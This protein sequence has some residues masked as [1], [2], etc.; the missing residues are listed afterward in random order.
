MARRPSRRP[1]LAAAFLALAAFP[2]GSALAAPAAP[3]ARPL[4]ALRSTAYGPILVDARGHT[5]YLF[6]KDKTTSS[7]CYGQC[8]TFWPPLLAG[9]K[10]TA[11]SGVHASLLHTTK[12]RDGH[13]QVTYAGHPLYL[14]A[15]DTRAGQ[16]AGQ[17]VDAFGA[18]WYV[19]SA[20]GKKVEK[21]QAATSGGGY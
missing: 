3:A 8:A 7:T 1:L 11:G 19:L 16:T 4:V 12:R 5:L 14:F 6:Q 18:E 15:K 21:K 2:A 10:A 9:A 13:L 20:A 17:N